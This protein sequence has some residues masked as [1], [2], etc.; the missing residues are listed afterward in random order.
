MT[1][2]VRSASMSVSKFGAPAGRVRRKL[3]IA[4][5]VSNDTE[6]T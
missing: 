3:W 4:F 5:G 6:E 1:D 2:S